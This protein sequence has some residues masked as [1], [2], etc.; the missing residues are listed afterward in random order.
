MV[1]SDIRR[2]AQNARLSTG[3]NVRLSCKNVHSEKMVDLHRPIFR[4]TMLPT[5]AN[6]AQVKK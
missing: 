2:N 6:I 1:T 5:E 4:A 3:E